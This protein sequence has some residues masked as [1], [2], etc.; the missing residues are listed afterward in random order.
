[1]P[2]S[3]IYFHAQTLVGECLT[4]RGKYAEAEPLL[5][6]GYDGMLQRAKEMRPGNN[7]LTDA[8]QRLVRL[9]EAWGK[10]ELAADWRAKVAALPIR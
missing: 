8:G 6:A 3:Y 5:L 4:A 1:V 2:E 10:P 7:S 9:Y